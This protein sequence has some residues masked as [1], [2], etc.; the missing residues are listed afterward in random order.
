MADLLLSPLIKIVVQKS[1][2]SLVQRIGEMWGI[3]DQRKRLHGKLLAVQAVLTDAE[4][5][6]DANPAVKYW[7]AELKSVAYDPDDVLDEFCYEELRRDAMKRGHKAGNVSRLFS[8]ENPILFRFKM[9]RKLKEVV[10][11]IDELVTEM[12]RFK[13]VQGRQ[14]RA[15][16]HV[17]THSYVID[18][19][20]VGRE[21]DRENLV[22]LLIEVCPTINPMVLP[23][24]GMGGLGKTT[25]AQLVYNDPKVKEYFN[26]QLW[27]CVRRV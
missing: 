12:E 4:E 22:K 27:I 19:E 23:V 5:K 14:G 15:V 9:S 7:L 26:L 1:G 13:F 3:D 16:H 10:G 18:S 8:L 6:G 21:K 2:D 24:V 20:V 17:I 11:R 25:L